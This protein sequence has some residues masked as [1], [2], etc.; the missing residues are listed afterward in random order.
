M[1]GDSFEARLGPEG[2]FAEV[3]GPLRKVLEGSSVS[4]CSN[5]PVYMD[6]SL[7][8]FRHIGVKHLL[9]LVHSMICSLR[10][11]VVLRRILVQVVVFVARDL[12]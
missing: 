11:T 10:H 6:G 12:L 5:Y 9:N 3:F 1:N 2:P 7:Q 4:L 8:W